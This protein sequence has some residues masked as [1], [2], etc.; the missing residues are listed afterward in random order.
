[1]DVELKSV[2]KRYGQFKA[3]NE[4]SLRVESGEL[5]VV[6]GPSGSG[7]TTLLRVL[8]GLERPDNG[9]VIF[10][11]SDVTDTPPGKRN[12]SMVF[13]NY[14]LYPHKTILE[15][16]LLPIEGERDAP[17]R[18][19]EVATK[20]RIQDLLDRYPGSLS[21]GQQQR[22]ALA[23]ALVKL[24]SL[25]LM[26]EPLSNL[27]A[28]LRFSARHLLRELQ[29]ESNIT[30]VYVTHDQ[31]E[32]MAIADRIAIINEGRV[33]QVGTPEEV[34][35]DPVDRFVA[36]FIG[37]PPMTIIDGTGVRAEDVIVGEG[38]RKGTVRDVEFM[39]DRYLIYISEEG[40]ELRAFSTSKVRRG[41]EISFSVRKIISFRG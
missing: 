34:Y 19:K 11:G 10:G 35:N 7:K 9:K 26:D 32:A 4:V 36:S 38:D 30:T 21:G 28:P 17:S 3:L 27:D 22:V 40:R 31:A 5:F 15:N 16:L 1:V 41:E 12:I 25:F 24:P 8:A 33:I 13:Q 20:L 18:V 6:L 37:N 23:R 2:T 39:G 14:A 29:R